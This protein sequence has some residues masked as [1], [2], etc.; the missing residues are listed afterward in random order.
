MVQELLRV[1]QELLRGPQGQNYF[2]TNIKTLFGLLTPILAGQCSG[3]FQRL[4]D[5]DIS[6][7]DPR[8]DN[9]SMNASDR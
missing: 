4:H 8:G 3:V 6:A 2:H 9:L 7:S 1:P 5:M